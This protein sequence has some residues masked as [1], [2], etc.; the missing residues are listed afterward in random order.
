MKVTIDI[1]DELI[2]KWKAANAILPELNDEIK[3][4]WVEFETKPFGPQRVAAI[5]QIDAIVSRRYR[6]LDDLDDTEAHIRDR[7]L[8]AL[9][10][11]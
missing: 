10:K 3:R 9:R 7:V 4:A 11:L 8:D 5:T 2:R 6:A 1:P